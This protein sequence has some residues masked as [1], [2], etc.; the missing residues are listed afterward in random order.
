[1][2]VNSFDRLSRTLAATGTRSFV[3]TAVTIASS[4]SN[5]CAAAICS[6]VSRRR[7]YGSANVAG[8]SIRMSAETTSSKR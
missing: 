5:R 1:M 4:R 7:K 6:A 8:S 3:C 2:D